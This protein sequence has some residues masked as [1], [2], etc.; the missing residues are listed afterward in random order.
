MAHSG[1]SEILPTGPK[2]DGLPCPEVGA[3]SEDKHRLVFL[4]NYLFSRGMKN[5]WD[6]RVYVDLYSGP[7]LARV[8]GT[9]RLLWGSPLLALQV[10]DPFDK[11]IF[12][13][14]NL[15]YMD[16]LQK[17]CGQISP[18]ADV[19][20]VHGDCNDKAD[21]IHHLIPS[22]PKVLS[23]C[24]V[25]P[26]DLS[27]KFSTIQKIAAKRVDFLVLL[28]LQMD[29]GRNET[30][31]TNPTNRKLDEFLGNSE[32]RLRWLDRKI[33][34]PFP[35]FIAEEYAKSMEGMGYLPVPFYRMK[36]V[37]S[38]SNTPLYRLAL[39]SKH[40]LALKFWEEVLNYSDSQTKFR[41][42]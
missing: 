8:K 17:R 10:P 28:A 29:G 36:Q 22:G 34:V 4:Y 35:Q 31:Y 9:D 11:Y 37:R 7:G 32:W 2:N 30:H 39:F 1:M 38:D 6:S 42:C 21:E 24:F 19:S 25:D 40:P 33:S 20:Y 41:F 14:S 13:E 5:R 23:S 12:C 3:W 18:V 16:A 27:V 15:E 26:F